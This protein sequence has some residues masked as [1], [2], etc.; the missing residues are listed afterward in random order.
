MYHTIAHMRQAIAEKNFRAKITDV[1]QE[2]GVLSI[3]GE[4]C[5][6]I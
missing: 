3:Q 5:H 4:C 2:L 6:N 1:T